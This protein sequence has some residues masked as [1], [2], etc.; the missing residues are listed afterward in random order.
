VLGEAVAASSVRVSLGELTTEEEIARAIAAFT[1][2]L[3]RSP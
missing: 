1:R 3:R 2:V